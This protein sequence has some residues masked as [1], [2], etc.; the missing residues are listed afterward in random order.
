M[1]IK[2]NSPEADLQ[3]F[4]ICEIDAN[5][6][7]ALIYR[8]LLHTNNMEPTGAHSYWGFSPA[9]DLLQVHASALGHTC[10]AIAA[11]HA[12]RD[13]SDTKLASSLSEA[14]ETSQRPFC[15]LL[16]SPGDARHVLKTIAQR[17]RHSRG[18]HAAPAMHL[19]VYER[20]AEVLARIMLQLA[21]ACDWELPLRQ[22]AALWLELY[23]NA[24]IQTRTATYLSSKLRAVLVDVLCNERGPAPLPALFDFSL[25]KHRQRDE[26]E[27][28]LKSWAE[29]VPFDMATLR[30][31]RLRH[32]YG[33]RYDFRNNL[34]DWDYQMGIKP[35]VGALHF[36]T[37]REWRNSGVAFEFGDCVYSAPNRTMASFVEGREAGRGSVAR[38]G[39]WGD[40]LVGPYHA[41]GTATYVPTDVEA[42]AADYAR[43]VQSA[44]LLGSARAAAGPAAGGAGSSGA[45][46]SGAGAGGAKDKDKETDDS[47]SSSKPG[48]YAW[49]LFD[50]SA[51][52]HGSE[53]WR[54]HAVEIA[55]HNVLS[56]LFEIE[57]GRPYI[58]RQEHDVHSGLADA[59][60]LPE[61]AV[62]AKPAGAAAS[63]AT[64][65][66][67][68]AEPSAVASSAETAAG[69][70]VD[71]AAG[72]AHPPELLLAAAAAR[73]R[74]IAHA[75]RGVKIT[76]LTGDLEGDWLAKGKLAGK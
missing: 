61:V 65:A 44:E 71:V 49:Q 53:Q 48:N 66:A 45:G 19:C 64:S 39:Y 7:H 76:F 51:R 26:L 59:N 38:R 60:L 31:H 67:S 63:V 2:R 12:S 8:S 11:A 56:W 68:A 29:G 41:V 73:A 50:I 5:S 13:S 4:S 42:E 15:A 69:A 74:T 62:A 72:S 24:L 32:H 47:S 9:V 75:F 70:G 30:D 43:Q 23:G 35:H 34:I 27:E 20:S 28:V 46:A 36:S 22:R 21:I 40:I 6:R 37:F 17:R 1:Y 25:L 18:G 52:R 55:V 3:P 58:M 14:S 57:C 16:L 33:A 10:A 54:H